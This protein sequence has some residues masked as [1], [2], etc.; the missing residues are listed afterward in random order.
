[1]DLDTVQVCGKGRRKTPADIERARVLVRRLREGCEKAGLF[2]GM[3]K[4]KI[5]EAMR[6]TREEVWAETKDAAGTRR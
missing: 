1:M 4:E 5:L 3:S 6:R 2:K